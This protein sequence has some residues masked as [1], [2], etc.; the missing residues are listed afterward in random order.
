MLKKLVLATNN[1]GKVEE[2][3]VLLLDLPVEILTLKDFPGMVMPEED[4]STFSGNAAKKAQAVAFFSGEMALADDSGLEVEALNGRPGVW[5][6]RYANEEGNWEA[7]NRKLLKELEGIPPEKRRASFK[8]AIAVAF[9]DGKTE[10]IEEDC[11]GIITERP[12]GEGGF[13]YDPL[14]YYEPDGLTFAQMSREEKNKVSHR[15]KALR[16]TRELLKKLI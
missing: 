16:R 7:N 15:G 14:F 8:C 3:K 10:V 4:S 13:G 6:A 1:R 11:P 2:L 9:P 5:S 12:R